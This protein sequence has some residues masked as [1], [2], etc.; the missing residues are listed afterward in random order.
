MLLCFP[1]TV[2]AIQNDDKLG[3]ATNVLD[4]V[5]S[6]AGMLG[7]KG[8]AV[9]ALCGVATTVLGM[10]FGAEPGPSDVEIM[11]D[12]IQEQTKVIGSMIE[13]QTKI[14]LE[15]AQAQIDNNNQQTQILTNEIKSSTRTMKLEMTYQLLD[16]MQGRAELVMEL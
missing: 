15:V 14:L 12:M 7:P 6:V 5:G 2:N 4:T 1:G 11:G 16:D 9:A 13:A 8:Q 3:I 10:I